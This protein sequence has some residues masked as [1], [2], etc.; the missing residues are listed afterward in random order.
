MAAGVA[1]AGYQSEVGNL[2]KRV[3]PILPAEDGK[4]RD[5]TMPCFLHGCVWEYF[6]RRPICCIMGTAELRFL[7]RLQ[8]SGRNDEW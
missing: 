2:F 4:E 5:L 1:L 6:L 7:S 3:I 8:M